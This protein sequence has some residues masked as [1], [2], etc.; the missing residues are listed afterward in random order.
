MPDYK[1]KSRML[2]ISLA[3][4]LVT[5]ITYWQIYRCGFIDFDDPLYVTENKIVQDG[6]T[7]QGIKWAFTTSHAYN[8]HPLTWL[9]HMLDC[10]LFGLN[11]AGHHLTNVLLHI[12]NTILLF[13]VLATATGQFWQAAFVA[14]LFALHPLH[15]ESVAWISERKDVLSTF[16]WLLTIGFYIRYAHKPRLIAYLPVIFAFALGLMAKQMLVTL[17]F[18]LLLMDYW[19]LQRFPEYRQ[20]RR[21]RQKQLSY[22]PLFH[23]CME[24][25]PLLC[26]SIRASIIVYR[27]QDKVALVKSASSIPLSYRIGN[28][29]ASYAEYIL[30]MLYPIHL[31]ILYPHPERNLP[32]GQVII[33]ACILL[34]LSVIII[35]LS[36]T[37]R[38]LLVGWLWYLGTLVPVIGIA[39][40]GL[41]AMADRY[42][43]IPLVGIFIIVVYGAAELLSK[44]K[45]AKI[46]AI[47]G[48]AIVLSAL[49]LCTHSQLRYWQNSIML[50]EHT[51]AVTKN[52]DIMHYNLGRL[53][54]DDGKIEQAI[55]HFRQSV[56]I[57]P[58]Q[59]KIHKNLGILL[60]QQGR[61]NEAIEEFR[62][63]LKYQPDDK[64][65]QQQLQILLSEREK[66]PASNN[67]TN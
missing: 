6:L 36:H 34:S 25:T 50:Y 43:Y 31:G 5:V 2:F 24:K 33:A 55:E 4:V 14:G 21:Q 26:L 30:K 42:T 39:Q 60:M 23:C 56:T 64:T 46:A 44:L 57:K 59:P 41:Q 65:A 67:N 58:D 19:P 12:A 37:R 10:Q 47:A 28:A 38:W 1:N 48:S 35:Y 32:I 18:V 62:R 54:L 11:P 8:W 61:N 22:A 51:V 45:C 17:P 16:F 52:N 29:L 66:T 13:I 15:V 27:I 49:S 7:W 3:L 9:S 20:S 53:L 40:V 63:V